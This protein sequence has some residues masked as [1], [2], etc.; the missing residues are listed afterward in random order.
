MR[1]FSY[2]KEPLVCLR[3]WDV[4]EFFSHAQSE[5]SHTQVALWLL[6]AKAL[7]F[8]R[9]ITEMLQFSAAKP[10]WC[11]VAPWF[12]FSGDAWFDIHSR[13]QKPAHPA[14]PDQP[15]QGFSGFLSEFTTFQLH[16]SIHPCFEPQWEASNHMDSWCFIFEAARFG[17]CV[18]SESQLSFLLALFCNYR[19]PSQP[20]TTGRHK[21]SNQ[22]L[23]V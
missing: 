11:S 5:S 16:P 13:V 7:N 1:A 18:F 20:E 3:I 19:D 4:I 17:S 2:A 15:R 22:G 9:A 21:N 10:V 8:D 23:R 14:A 12:C 6:M